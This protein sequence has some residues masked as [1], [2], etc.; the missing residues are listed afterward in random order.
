MEKHIANGTVKWF[1]GEKGFGCITV[2]AVEGG[3]AEQDVFGHDSSIWMS[4][5]TA[6]E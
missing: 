6:A 1:N 5:Y 4:G 3:A 2:E